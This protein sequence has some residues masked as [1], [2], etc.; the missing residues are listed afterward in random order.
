MEPKEA[1]HRCLKGLSREV[2]LEFKS[3]KKINVPKE[4]VDENEKRISKILSVVLLLIGIAITVFLISSPYQ[5][6][7]T[8]VRTV[9]LIPVLLGLVISLWQGI[10]IRW[11]LRGLREYIVV[12]LLFV[13]L[14]IALG[15]IFLELFIK[16]GINVGI[17]A[18]IMMMCIGGLFIIFSLANRKVAKFRRK[19]G[20]KVSGFS[21]FI[22]GFVMLLFGAFFIG[23]II[24]IISATGADL[25][26]QEQIGWYTPPESE[27]TRIG[28]TKYVYIDTTGKVAFK[29]TYEQNRDFSEGLAAV[30]SDNRQW[31]YI[32]TA[33]DTVIDFLYEY[34]GEFHEGKAA[35]GS[36]LYGEYSYGYISADGDTVV[37]FEYNK[38]SR[39][40]EGLA[41]VGK[42]LWGFVNDKGEILIDFQYN[43][44]HPFSEG[45][46][47]AKKNGKWGYINKKN[48]LIIPHQYENAGQFHSNRA[49]VA[50]KKDD[51]DEYVYINKQGEIVIDSLYYRAHDFSDGYGAVGHYFYDTAGNKLQTERFI[52][53]ETF[54]DSMARI[55]GYHGTDN[56]KKQGYG[57]ITHS[58]ELVIPPRYYEAGDF[59]SGLAPVRLKNEPYGYINKKG[60]YVICPRFV[61]ASVFRN[62]LAAVKIEI[63]KLDSAFIEQTP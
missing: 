62:G 19:H 20:D 47:A 6:K 46:A 45:L 44:I 55:S 28:E 52:Y 7:F 40:S 42:N 18:G 14:Y 15:L 49:F 12:S 29:A 35:V 59:S 17:L 10:S 37:P 5:A 26:I 24:S 32:N 56:D 23:G 22:N 53:V 13:F 4:P 54:S 63:S 30:Q 60:D 43:E 38:I 36:Y 57:Y 11:I 16:A 48:E 27:E 58:G 39:F 51:D 50:I 25:L 1:A 8:L 33:G 3:L 2:F 41:A 34:A 21:L 61:E 31:G 9:L